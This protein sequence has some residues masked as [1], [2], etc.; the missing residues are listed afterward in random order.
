MQCTFPPLHFTF[1]HD[2]VI[3]IPVVGHAVGRE[4]LADDQNNNVM[5]LSEH[6]RL[7]RLGRVILFFPSFLVSV[8]GVKG[9]HC[10]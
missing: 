1:H 6:C 9:P 3:V 5:E 10:K 7:L 8:R 2:D 4:E